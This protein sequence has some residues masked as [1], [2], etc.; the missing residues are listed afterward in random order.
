MHWTQTPAARSRFLLGPRVAARHLGARGQ[1][2][3]IGGATQS[4]EPRTQHC[5]PKVCRLLVRHAMPADQAMVPISRSGGCVQCLN[6]DLCSFTHQHLSAEGPAVANTVCYESHCQVREAIVSSQVAFCLPRW[7]GAA[8]IRG[9][10]A[11]SGSLYPGSDT[12]LRLHPHGSRSWLTWS[13]LHAMVGIREMDHLCSLSLKT[14]PKLSP[15]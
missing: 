4:P 12:W 2:V 7:A 13:S 11:G 9:S 5:S 15:V 1:G 3:P 14:N 8:Q 6:P 10:N